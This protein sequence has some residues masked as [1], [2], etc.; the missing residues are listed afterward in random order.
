MLYDVI[1]ADIKSAMKSKNINKRDVLK[2]V[3]TKAQAE[4]KENKIEMSDDVVLTAIS[5]EL[6]Q[7][8]QTKDAISSKPDS[9]LYKSTVEKISILQGYLPSQLCEDECLAEVGKILNENIGLPKGK[10]TGLIMKALKG[11]AD[12]KL[13]K[14]CID[15]L[16]KN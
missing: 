6:K 2:Q 11:K 1:L 5:K 12:N 16:T 10:V 4:V 13:I 8:N 3:Q 9:D 15:A 14:D 7:L